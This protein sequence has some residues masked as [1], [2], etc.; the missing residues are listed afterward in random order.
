VTEL[1]EDAVLRIDPVMD[2]VVATIPVGRRPLGVAVGEGA[3]WVVNHD[4][5]TLSR[6]DPETNRVVADIRLGSRAWEV[7]VDAH[8]VW[9]THEARDPLSANN[10][11]SRV[12]PQSNRVIVKIPVP[13]DPEGV[14]V[15]FGSVWVASREDDA[16]S[17]IDPETNHVV[18]QSIPLHAATRLAIGPDGVWVSLDDGAQGALARIDPQ[19]NTVAARIDFGRR[20]PYGVAVAGGVVWLT[21]RETSTVSRVDLKTGEIKQ[22]LVVDRE[23]MHAAAGDDAVWIAHRTGTLTRIDITKITD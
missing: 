9:V 22:P 15:G 10:F 2:R 17:R 12:D 4:N 7:A 21:N 19:T 20:R 14:A 13:H 11:V 16:V 5:S 1:N 6:V 23:P 3:V 18:G 8:G